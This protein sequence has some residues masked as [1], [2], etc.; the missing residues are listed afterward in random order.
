MFKLFFVQLFFFVVDL[1]FFVSQV[2]CKNQEQGCIWVGE[3]RDLQS[4]LKEGCP[5]GITD[6]TLGCGDRM[7]RRGLPDHLQHHC[8]L[9]KVECKYCGLEAAYEVIMDEHYELCP[10]VPVTCPNACSNATFQREDLASHA[11]TCPLEPIHCE[12]KEIGCEVVVARKDMENHMHDS[13]GSHQLLT[14]SALAGLRLAL[15]AQ[16]TETE[17]LKEELQKSR[18]E[19]ERLKTLVSATRQISALPSTLVSGQTRLCVMQQHLEAD[20]ERSLATPFLPVVLKMDG[21]QQ[22]K[23]SRELWV[24]S[25]FYAGSF[26]Y[27]FC[28]CVYA[29][30]CCNGEYT[31]LSAYVHLMPGE[32]DD[33]LDWP[34]EEEITVELQNQLADSNHWA[35]DCSF[36]RTDPLNRRRRVRGDARTRANRGS[37]TPT[38]I[39]L[40]KLQRDAL[41]QNCQYLKNNCLYFSV[42]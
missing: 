13:Q 29:D 20:A 38:F 12:F 26:G 10:K 41:H 2:K 34:I 42:Y 35:V 3:L 7:Q 18:H 28:L 39:L 14:L 27:K 5:Y 9:R 32:F 22:K 31:H 17:Q 21:Y 1:L 23:D 6:C 25:P 16:K 11:E 30:G 36:K 24:S 37:G 15:Q 8:L 40:A 4:H 19:Q 33:Q